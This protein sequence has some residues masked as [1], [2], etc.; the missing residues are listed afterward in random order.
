MRER[1]TLVVA[2]RDRCERLMESLP[3]HPAPVILVDNGSSDGT[4]GEVR[5]RV[6]EVDV[7]EMGENRG[8]VARN[9]GV[10]RARTPYVAF[11]DDDSWWAPGALERA[12]DLLDEHP[13][14]ALLAARVVVGPDQ[15]LDPI[16][17]EMAASPLPPADLG[18]SILGFLACAV[19]VRR[20]AFLAVGGFDDAIFFFGEEERVALDLAAAGWQ[21]AYVE[22]LVAHHHPSPSPESSGRQALALRNRVL[23]AVMRRPWRVVAVRAMEAARQGPAGRQALLAAAP[24]L[25]RAL[26]RRKRL[27][28]QVEAARALLDNRQS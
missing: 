5:R 28:P 12:A 16:S 10:E 25:P 17:A 6:P 7:V 20:D 26:R 8:A 2:T 22:E 23:T 3:Q 4:P 27:P 13:R 14:T 15:R 19:V 9:V 11:A 21:L 1:V 24:R 18:P